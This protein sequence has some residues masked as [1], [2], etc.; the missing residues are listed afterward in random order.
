M[1][2][3]PP[4]DDYEILHSVAQPL[5]D[6]DQVALALYKYPE[7]VA[8]AI[9]AL[10]EAALS[11][12]L[13]PQPRIVEKARKSVFSGRI[14]AYKAH[15]SNPVFWRRSGLTSQQ[16]NAIALAFEGASL[17]DKY[18]LLEGDGIKARTMRITSVEFNK[19][20]LTDYVKQTLKNSK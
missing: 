6:P 12:D 7:T 10:K 17:K 4:P 19:A 5:C 18:G 14:Q 2:T 8:Q 15:Y 20:A 1:N 9:P 11:S 16:L 3:T 13:P